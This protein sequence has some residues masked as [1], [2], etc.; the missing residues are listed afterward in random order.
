MTFET[1]ST[2]LYMCVARR[3]PGQ[4]HMNLFCGVF[5]SPPS[6]V[7]HLLHISFMCG[8]NGNCCMCLTFYSVLEKVGSVCWRC[9]RD[10]HEW[11]RLQNR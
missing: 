5:S 8:N 2:V 9:G 11:Y 10:L 1:R 6:F 3:P 4:I 7:Q